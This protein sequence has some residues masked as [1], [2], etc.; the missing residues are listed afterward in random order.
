MKAVFNGHDHVYQRTHQID[1][2]GNQ[3]SNGIYNVTVSGGNSMRW[4]ES[5]WMAKFLNK[6]K[7]N[8]AT[9]VP[10][11]GIWP[12]WQGAVYMM[13]NGDKAIIEEFNSDS[14]YRKD[15]SFIM[16]VENTSLNYDKNSMNLSKIENYPNPFNPECYIPLEISNNKSSNNTKI[17]IYNILGQVVREVITNN[18]SNSV[19]WDGRD[20]LR[21]E[22]SSGMYFYETIINNKTQ[23]CKKMLMLK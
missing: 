4:Q 5:L 20:N 16:T 14:N 17:K 21:K 18:A 22:V 8:D 6:Y 10:L 9:D 1:K 23:N 7:G 2:D 3:V 12:G 11:V 19:Y 13:I 15:D